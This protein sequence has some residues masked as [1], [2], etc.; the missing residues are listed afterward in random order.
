MAFFK[1]DPK[2]AAEPSKTVAVS[3]EKPV[4][5]PVDFKATREQAAELRGQVNDA[6]KA[7][8]TPATQEKAAVDGVA[9]AQKATG[10]IDKAD[11]NL[12]QANVNNSAKGAGN[13]QAHDVSVAKGQKVDALRIKADAIHAQIPAAEVKAKGNFDAAKKDLD[14]KEPELKGRAKTKKVEALKKDAYKDVGALKKEEATCRS[15]ARKIETE[16]KKGQGKEARDG[17][18]SEVRGRLKTIEGLLRHGEGSSVDMVNSAVAARAS[19]IGKLKSAGIE[20]NE[21]QIS[22]VDAI[23]AQRGRYSEKIRAEKASGGVTEKA[24]A[25]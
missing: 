9:L 21:A 19:M 12:K 2:P 4:V 22:A 11:A 17:F 10:L 5:K 13:K 25:R 23:A 3:H 14:A 8:K 20:P 15:T 16:A 6:V 24:P 18:V 7:S 1:K